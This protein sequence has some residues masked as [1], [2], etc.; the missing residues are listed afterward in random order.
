MDIIVCSADAL[1]ACLCRE[2]YLLRQQV[3][4]AG[5]RMEVTL[6]WCVSIAHSINFTVCRPTVP[7]VWSTSTQSTTPHGMER[8][9]GQRRRM[10]KRRRKGKG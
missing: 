6:L 3:D 2:V 7:T 1:V 8:G 4:R 5:D 9:N 10:G